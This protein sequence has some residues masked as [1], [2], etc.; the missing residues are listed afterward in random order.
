M[1]GS[2]AGGLF[3][4]H[5]PGSEGRTCTWGA[6]KPWG[7][8]RLPRH[9]RKGAVHRHLGVGRVACDPFVRQARVQGV[10]VIPPRLRVARFW[11]S[12]GRRTVSLDVKV[13]PWNT[14]GTRPVFL[15]AVALG[16]GPLAEPAEPRRGEHPLLGGQASI[17]ECEPACRGRKTRQAPSGTV[18]CDAA[19]DRR[20]AVAS[21]WLVNT[22]ASVGCAGGK[23]GR[24]LTPARWEDHRGSGVSG[25]RTYGRR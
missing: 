3:S 15:R 7:W 24:N 16:L 17:L 12:L 1:T 19:L 9:T 23:S 10:G 6:G 21:C 25:P 11:P 22:R 5:G 13:K 4:T 14:A 20:V 18:V 8:T 2:W